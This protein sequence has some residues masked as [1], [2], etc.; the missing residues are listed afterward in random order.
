MLHRK[1]IKKYQIRKSSQNV[2]SKM[3]RKHSKIHQENY[4]QKFTIAQYNV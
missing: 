3:H 1:Y 4:L 2:T